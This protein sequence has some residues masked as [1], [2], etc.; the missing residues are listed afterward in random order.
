[1]REAWRIVVGRPSRIPDG[2]MGLLWVLLFSSIL[3]CAA[4]QQSLV[5]SLPTYH[6]TRKIFAVLDFWNATGYGGDQLSRMASEMFVTAMKGSG[7]FLL[8]DRERWSRVLEE[9]AAAQAGELGPQTVAKV[10][11]VSGAQYIALGTV[12]EFGLRESRGSLGETAASCPDEICSRKRDTRAVIEVRVIEVKGGRVLRRERAEGGVKGLTVQ[13]RFGRDRVGGE[14][15]Y[16]EMVA[17]RTL[18]RAIDRCVY[19]I[20]LALEERPWEGRIARIDGERVFVVG[21]KDVGLPVR[22]EVEICKVEMRAWGPA[23]GEAPEITE[24]VIGK[25]VIVRVEEHYSVVQ[26]REG[27][28]FSFQDLVRLTNR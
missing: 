6:G 25:G 4:P 28:G 18:R 10:G 9:Q 20:C 23:S 13:M 27:G 12:T 5:D 26:I 17:S 15:L 24:K 11:Q 19:D 1:M 7:R 22:G 3:G 2:R 8:V 14:I 16:D 21:G